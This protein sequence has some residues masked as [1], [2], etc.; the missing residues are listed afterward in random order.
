MFV[1]SESDVPFGYMV[2]SF[3]TY[4]V[5]EFPR[6]KSVAMYMQLGERPYQ[7]PH[8][9]R[10]DAPPRTSFPDLAW[11]EA[12]HDAIHNIIEITSGVVNQE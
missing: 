8:L 7:D 5:H 1:A 11:K 10:Q 3:L 12:A 4:A 2:E 9:F 6:L